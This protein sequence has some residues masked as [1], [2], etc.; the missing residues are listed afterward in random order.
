MVDAGGIASHAAIVAREYGIRRILLVADGSVWIPLG[1]GRRRRRGAGAGGHH[2]SSGEPD[3]N[4]PL[5]RHHPA[6]GY[7]GRVGQSRR[8]RTLG[9]GLI[10]VGA[11]L[12]CAGARCAYGRNGFPARLGRTLMVRL[13][14]HVHRR[15]RIRCRL[16]RDLRWPEL[17]GRTIQPEHAR[18]AHR[19]RPSGGAQLNLIRRYHSHN[20][21]IAFGSRQQPSCS[22]PQDGPR[23]MAAALTFENGSSP[24][25]PDL[26]CSKCP[27]CGSETPATIACHTDN[28]WYGFTVSARPWRG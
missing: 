26:E 23:F 13:L 4:R 9:R 21:Q 15:A 10:R 25:G 5:R 24:D 28:F 18:L 3:R 8:R 2:P 22:Q 20:W 27:V 16:V 14:G 6:D 11:R 19:A 1:A 7:F 12:R 17:P